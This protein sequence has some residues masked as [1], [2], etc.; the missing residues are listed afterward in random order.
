VHFSIKI[1]PEQNARAA[2]LFYVCDTGPGIRRFRCGGGFRYQLTSG[3]RICDSIT[4][5]RIRALAIPPAWTDIWICER[6]NGHIQATGRDAKLRKQYCY[7]RDW[8]EVRDRTKYE[9]ILEF[10]RALPRIRRRV[11]NDLAKPGLVREKVLATVVSLLDKTLI[12]VGNDEYAKQNGS[13]GLTT[14]RN[15]HLDVS[16][17]E[18][19]FHF[20]GKSGKTWR[21]NL[22][23]RRIARVV[24]SIQELPGQLLFQYVDGG[25]VIRAID[26]NDVNTYLRVVANCDVSAKDFRTWAGTVHAMG[27]FRAL[28]QFESQRQAKENVRR[29]ITAVAQLLGNTPVICRKCYIHP[30]IIAWYLDGIAVRASPEGTTRSGLIGDEAAALRLLDQR[31]KVNQSR[32]TPKR[33]R[34]TGTTG[35][36]SDERAKE[37]P[38]HAHGLG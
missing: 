6:P 16:G 10:A 38:Q 31:M 21:L 1:E 33:G 4:L 3:D 17:S 13:Y 18:L 24:R 7:H 12:R 30:E 36:D 27:A 9:R 25:G 29:V 32:G 5:N 28:G 22:S 8:R 15:R 35:I 26:S 14:L 11:G 2:G 20:K 37:H 23:D 19:R 34:K